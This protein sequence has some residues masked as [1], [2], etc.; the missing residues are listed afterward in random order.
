MKKT[1]LEIIKPKTVEYYECVLELYN[2]VSASCIQMGA[3]TK[4]LKNQCIKELISL[5]NENDKYTCNI[6]KPFIWVQQKL[7]TNQ[8]LHLGSTKA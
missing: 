7:D 4:Y 2:V 3:K 1:G 8:A 6:N 5:A